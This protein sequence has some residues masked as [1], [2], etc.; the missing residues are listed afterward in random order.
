MVLW[1]LWIWCIVILLLVLVVYSY[2]C[3]SSNDSI[4]V[5]Y[6]LMVFVVVV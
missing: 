3:G 5:L 4:F 2:Y 6:G 1:V